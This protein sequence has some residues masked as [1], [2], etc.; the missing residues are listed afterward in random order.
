[1]KWMI[2]E[3]KL[4][5]DQREVINDLSRE[6]KNTWIKG[7]AGSGKSV[8]LIHL[9]RDYLAK[10]SRA[11]VCVVV[12][13]NSLVDMLRVGIKELNLERKF[14]ISIPVMTI[15]KFDRSTEL[16]DAVFCDEV[17]DI[18]ANVLLSMNARAGKVI[19]AGD[20]A[21][22]IYNSVPGFNDAPA[23]PQQVKSILNANEKPLHYIYR[24]TR[25]VVA[26]LSSVFT[27]L[28][29]G[30]PNVEKNDVDIKFC[31]A[32]TLSKELEY[33]W[34]EATKTNRLRSDE[35]VA[36]LVP[37][38]EMII[39][40]A[41]YALLHNGAETW[42][43]V[44]NNFNRHDFD[45]LNDHLIAN[46]IPLIY[47][48]Q[49]YGSLTEADTNNKIILMTYNSAK[50]LD[51]DH[52]FLPMLGENIYIPENKAETLLFVA[53]SRSK[54]N[55]M[56]SYSGTLYSLMGKFMQGKTPFEIESLSTGS[57]GRVI[58]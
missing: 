17:Q 53:L 50:G 38:I 13:T 7:H 23:T 36:V 58:I 51:F 5:P 43:P 14:N 18:P 35:I 46:N 12:F 34:T 40:F 28:L 21:Q 54:Y 49:G 11:K 15:Y 42:E 8:L 1:M 9:L 22:S 41:D 44:F 45:N 25:S 19:V 57:A 52:V 33:V 56:V 16:Y 31:R 32:K 2:S 48:G 20:E 39:K 47:I 29:A 3:E 10:N 6:W 4:G 55:L 37:H 30:R 26:M 24:M 27:S